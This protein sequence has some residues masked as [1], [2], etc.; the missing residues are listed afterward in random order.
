MNFEL[1]LHVIIL[2]LPLRY[3]SISFPRQQRY[4]IAALNEYAS[5]Q[6]Q[7]ADTATVSETAKFLHACNLT[8]EKGVLSHAFISSENSSILKNVKSGW[9]YFVE[10][11]DTIG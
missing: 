6:P 7:P 8:F 10:W 11:A 5:E 2:Y 3:K 1:S 4:M 9:Q